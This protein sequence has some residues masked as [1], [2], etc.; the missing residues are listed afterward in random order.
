MQVLS[1]KTLHHESC[2]AQKR[3]IFG[4]KLKYKQWEA[5]I[6]YVKD[7]TSYDIT[8]KIQ[9]IRIAIFL[10][11]IIRNQRNFNVR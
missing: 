6:L 3:M 11:I 4:L 8:G 2:I 9:I 1:V 10:F 5:M 7:G